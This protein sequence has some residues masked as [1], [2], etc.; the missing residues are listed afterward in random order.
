[1]KHQI[2]RNITEKQFAVGDFVYQKLQPYIQKL[3]VTTAKQKLSFWYHG[4]HLILKRVEAMA[5]KLGLPEM[6]KIHWVLHVS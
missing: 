2:D 5:C 3:V 6:S 4:P 1:M